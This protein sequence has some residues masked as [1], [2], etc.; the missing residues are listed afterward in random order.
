MNKSDLDDETYL[1][2]NNSG[3]VDVIIPTKCDKTLQ[4]IKFGDFAVLGYLD[5]KGNACN[6]TLP[7]IPMGPCNTSG[8]VVCLAVIYDGP[9]SAT[10]DVGPN[11][12]GGNATVWTNVQNG[13]T[14]SVCLGNIGNNWYWAV[15]GVVDADIHTSGSDDIFGNTGSSKSDFGHLGSFPNPD[16]NTTDGTFYVVGLMDENGNTCGTITLPSTIR[17]MSPK[18]E[19]YPNPTSNMVNLLISNSE[20]VKIKIEVYDGLGRMLHAE[21]IDKLYNDPIGINTE[22]WV[23]GVYNVQVILI[24]D[25]NTVF[26]KRLIIAR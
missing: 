23:V 26:N 9:D 7:M 15:N 18:M 13:D 3:V 8:K 24:D 2:I 21:V 16:Q 12:N 11:S 6:L 22:G 4:D 20:G 10:V 5:K 14:L 25:S 1:E 17:Y 19:L